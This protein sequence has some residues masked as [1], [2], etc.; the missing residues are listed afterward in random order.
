MTVSGPRRGQA[1]RAGTE[2]VDDLVYDVGMHRGEDTAYYLAK[3]YRVVAIEANPEL[4][5]ECRKRFSVAIASGKL[6]IVEGAVA[7]ETE[8]DVPFYVDSVSVWGSI[9]PDWVAR[10]HVDSV[11]RRITVPAIDLAACMRE[12]GVPHYLKIDIEGADR[13]CFESLKSLPERPDFLSFEAESHDFDA[14]QADLDLLDQ[15]GYRRFAAVQQGRTERIATQTL[16]GERMEFRFRP[17]ASGP[18]GE[19]L[20]DRWGSKDW[21]A[22]RYRRAFRRFRVREALIKRPWMRKPVRL[23]YARSQKVRWLLGGY[24]DIHAGRGG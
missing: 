24:Y 6:T 20:P 22:R 17:E 14:V 9:D 10:K 5:S 8:G 15:L 19:D 23:V 7:P 13:L 2:V 4:V 12:H 16:A 1:S 18:F 11:Q 3:G 21:V